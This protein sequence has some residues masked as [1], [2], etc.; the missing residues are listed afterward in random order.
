[1][2]YNVKAQMT[3]TFF[4]VSPCNVHILLLLYKQDTHVKTIA[5]H[6]RSPLLCRLFTPFYELYKDVGSV[7][8]CREYFSILYKYLFITKHIACGAAFEPHNDNILL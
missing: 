6:M 7:C 2:L 8:I 3:C 4:F 1:V 5:L